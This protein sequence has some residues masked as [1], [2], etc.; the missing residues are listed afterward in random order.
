MIVVMGVPG[1]G[2]TS[3]I[4]KLTEKISGWKVV[5][6]GDIMFDIA[7]KQGLVK[8]R[9]EVRKLPI[10]TQRMIQNQVAARLAVEGKK[11]LLDTHCSIKTPKGYFPGIPF[12][13]L[14]KLKVEGLVLINA[15]VKD[16]LR[17]RREDKSRRRDVDGEESISESIM[18]NIAFLAAYSAY[19]GAPAVIIENRDGEMGKAVEK[20]KEILEG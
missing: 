4:Q 17:R 13:R 11:T 12:E 10:E 8:H 5:T 16:I 7:G 15:P 9:D 3:V 2:K 18:V 19:T 20:L 6:W 1:A 14:K